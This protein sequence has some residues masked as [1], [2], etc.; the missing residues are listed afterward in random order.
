MVDQNISAKTNRVLNIIL[1]SL[2][3]I[4]VRVWY[5]G[6][7][8][9][10]EH[11]VLAR[12]PQRRV[13]I[14]HVDRATIRDRFN[15]P[16]ALNK[17]QYNAA[18]CYAEI[19]Q[20]PSVQWKKDEKGKSVRVQARSEYIRKLSEILAH[21]LAMDASRIEDTIH[22]KASLFPHTPF[23]I[24]ED[25]SEE[26]YYRL[27][28]MLKDWVG[29]EP[30]RTTKRFYPQGK[31]GADIIGYLGA[32]SQKEYWAIAQEMK[33]LQGYIEQREAGDLV[34]LPKGYKTPLEVRER[35]KQ[36]QERAYTI[37]DLVG[38][39]GV[40]SM[41]DEQ[42]R[43]F[44]GK[45]MVE[46]DVKGNFLRELP[47]SR[48][49]MSGQRILLTLSS[50]LQ[51]FAESLLIQNEVLRDKH[52]S[53]GKFKFD[54]PWIKGGAIV[55]LVPKTG[56]VVALASY[57]RIDSNDFIPS[58]DPD[59][60]KKK[61]S[62]VIRYL[63][64]EAYVAE[65]WDGKRSLEREVKTKE[66]GYSEEKLPLTWERYLECIL[67]ATG[68][69][70]TGLN[71]VGNLKT[72]VRLQKEAE[73][74]L[75]LSGQSSMRTLFDVLY[76]EQEHVLT[77]N[78]NPYEKEAMQLAA[79]SPHKKYLDRFLSSIRYN[80]DKVLLIDLCQLIAKKEDFSDELLAAI[81][82]L[83]FSSYRTLTQAAV[84]LQSMLRPHVQ[85]L[86][87]NQNFAEWRKTHFKEFLKEK[88]R[89]EKEKKQYARPYTEYLELLEKQMFKAFWQE[90]RMALVYTF[91]LDKSLPNNSLP[92]PYVAL[93]TRLKEKCKKE[94]AHSLDKLKSSLAPLSSDLALSY[95]KTMRS[96]EELSRP[97]YGK[98]RS[99]RHTKG[100][101]IEKHLASAFY[102]L[103]GFSYGR[104]QTYRQSAPQGSVF[105]L[106]T[107]YA[108]LQERYHMLMEQKRSLSQLNPLTLIDDLKGGKKI[109]SNSQILGYTLDGQPL[110]RL[111]KGGRL[112]RSSHSNIGRID[113]VGALEQSSNLY[114]AL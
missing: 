62:S 30:Q 50:E 9:H 70:K 58:H 18:V 90:N 56:E 23:V 88:R 66:S 108:A 85:E 69:I 113:I 106:V 20:I 64:N 22:G 112:P 73:D 80:D 13:E 14:E 55:A 6:V 10:E 92:E 61:R 24:K 27:R 98:Y 65:L 32:I 51:E 87:H 42:L 41:F 102:P 1:L 4:L 19:R 17:I 68:S 34:P 54:H 99:L 46:V 11:L 59:L 111:F 96:F 105:K 114:F 52:D 75:L 81:G 104:S 33:E 95:L 15:I 21:E 40:E 74:L 26:V 72:A 12:K 83:D 5:L 29:I 91:I 97:L 25:I 110:T 35:L 71:Q 100:A 3:L 45:K 39:S 47:G 76:S 89:E 36:L 7:I 37:N 48:K 49:S 77:G 78:V 60:Q 107:A 2:L 38:K 57:P 84:S 53:E 93:L 31:T 109:N 94:L 79:H 8:Q 63:E 103:C 44:Y 101:H 43:G 67:P 82:H 28:M 16:L 86:F